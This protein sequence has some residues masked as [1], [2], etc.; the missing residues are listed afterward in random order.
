MAPSEQRSG[1]L[2]QAP[3][4]LAIVLHTHMPY[5][6]GFGTWPFGEEWLWEAVATSYLPLLGV[7]ERAPLTLSL[8]PVLCDQLE[9]EAAMARCQA[10]LEEVR[11]ASHELDLEH[12]RAGDEAAIVQELE[13]S[14]AEY[15]ATARQ[16][17]G[18]RAQP[19]GLLSAL[20]A[21]ATWTSSATHAVLPLLA[22]DTG[23]A[24][25]VQSGIAS[26]RRRFGEWAGGFWLPEC[27]YAP[28]LDEVLEEAGAGAACV[29]LTSLFG[30]GDG[31]HLHPIQTQAGPVLWPVDRQTMALV[32]SEE[33]YPSHAAYRSYHAKTPRD[34][35]VWR[36]DERPYNPEAARALARRHAEDFVGAV[37]HR[38]RDGGVCV[39]ALDTELL[40]HWWYEGVYWLGAMV[41]EAARQGLALTTLDEAVDRHELVPAPADL[42]VSSW[43][44]GGDLRTWSAPRVA[45][46]AWQARTA[47]LRVLAQ[48]RRPCDRA[49]RELLAL[50][51]SDW[52]FQVTRD[53]AGDYPR[54]RAA[55]HTRALEAALQ[56]PGELDQA[57]RNLAPDLVGWLG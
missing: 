48:G 40:G 8:T 42:G 33:G 13:R 39:C 3:G 24:L 51:A 46:L 29:E 22:S 25:Q 34:H 6:E 35:R 9:D 15:A 49:L 7:L 32:W 38:V 14:A 16:L 28:W 21:H 43:G 19:G 57:L 1:L 56:A 20:G 5:V 37:R 31:R 44:E 10:F 27:G 26:H 17:A 2:R 30:T 53:L 36:N 52:A 45:D 18:I 47:E 41:D 55:A 23:I 11:P 12:Y 4:E 50:Q 54:E